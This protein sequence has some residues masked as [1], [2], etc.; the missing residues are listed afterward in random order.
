MKNK[1]IQKVSNLAGPILLIIT[2]L[3]FTPAGFA[4]SQEKVEEPV[5]SQYQD[6]SSTFKPIG[7]MNENQY[8]EESNTEN[9]ATAPDKDSEVY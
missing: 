5:E 6:D 2:S 8:Y 4:D 9:D 1:K 3:T 7:D